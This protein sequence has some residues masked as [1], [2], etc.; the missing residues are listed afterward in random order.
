M[1]IFSEGKCIGTLLVSTGLNNKTQSWNETP[2]G[3]FL[4]VS[5]TG[6]FPA[7]NLW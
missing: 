7:G 3:E 5:R 6:G 4:M 1:Y 2:A